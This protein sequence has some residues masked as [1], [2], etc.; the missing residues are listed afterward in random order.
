M[1]IVPNTNPAKEYATGYGFYKGG[2]WFHRNSTAGQVANATAN[3]RSDGFAC[4]MSLLGLIAVGDSS[5]SAAMKSANITKVATVEYK[6]TAFLSYVYHEQCTIV[7]G[8]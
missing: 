1:G 8:E 7:T 4:A 2:V 3:V 6:T 5:I